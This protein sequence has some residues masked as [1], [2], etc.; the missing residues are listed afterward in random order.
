MI[1]KRAV[2][3]LRAQDWFA[4]AIEFA[5]VVLGVFIGTQVSNWNAARIDRA[6][7][8]RMLAQLRPEL[9]RQ[10]DTYRTVDIYYATTRRF[11][12]TAFAGWNHDPA[13]SDN[14]FVIAAYQAS[15]ISG[16]G[17]NGTSWATIFGAERL[18]L[19]ENRAIRR[20]LTYLMETDYTPVSNDAVDTP[21]RANVR[22][23]IPLDVQ[24]AIRAQCG[25]VVPPGRPNV[26]VLPTSC[27][28]GLSAS[29]ATSAARALRDNP[30]LANDL[31]WHI[32]AEESFLS[33]AEPISQTA[34][35]LLHEL[36]SARH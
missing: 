26:I 21:Y 20:D 6:E 5:I 12:A 36:P 9:E 25:D 33:T 19:I 8:Q 31:R 13:V 34:Q 24:D 28:L 2:A 22:R 16:V 17:L 27:A 10:I 15:Q 3:K 7:T 11:A 18:R 29:Q 35:N 4:I 1:Y 14:D 32:A 23:I 30:D